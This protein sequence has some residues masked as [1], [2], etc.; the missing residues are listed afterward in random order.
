VVGFFTAALVALVIAVSAVAAS[1]GASPADHAGLPAPIAAGNSAANIALNGASKWVV[2]RWVARESG[3]LAALHLRIQ[4][5]GSSCRRGGR[6]GYGLGTGGSWRVTTHAVLPDGQPDLAHVLVRQDLRPCSDPASVVDVRQGVVRL[7]MRLP[8]VAGQEYA[9][10]IR[11]ADPAPGRN[12]SSVN[13]LYSGGGIVG[14][15]GRNERSPAA[16]DSYYGL[17]PREIVGYSRDG[18]RSWSLP[19]GPYGR[20]G[21]RAFLPTYLQEYS[22]GTVDGQPYYYATAPSSARLTMVF[23]NVSRPWTI[24]ALGAVIARAG[25]GT[26]TLTVDG[27][28]RARALVSGT[29][30]VRASIPPTVVLPRQTVK[31]TAS[32]LTIQD[33]AADTV[34]ARLAGMNLPSAPWRVQGDPNVSHAAPVYPLPACGA[35][36]GGGY[37][38]PVD[39]PGR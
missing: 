18:G 9:T 33:V 28:V 31:V 23:G 5:D 26:L 25:S 8:V 15:N 12:Y 36:C 2:V 22:D 38:V 13:F 29:G 35:A 39:L 3:T 11:N 37:G 19:G 7:G 17:D 34:W 10:V 4:A 32:G 27:A 6:T 20:P 14:A 16:Q 24:R 1:A 21:G 30:V